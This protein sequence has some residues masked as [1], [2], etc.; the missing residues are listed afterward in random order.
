MLGA[1]PQTRD[2]LPRLTNIAADRCGSEMGHCGS[3]PM[4]RYAAGRSTAQTLRTGDG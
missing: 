4:L 3:D 2:P 1:G